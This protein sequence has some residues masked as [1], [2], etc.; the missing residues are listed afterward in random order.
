MNTEEQAKQKVKGMINNAENLICMFSSEKE[1]GGLVFGERMDVYALYAMLT[2]HLLNETPDDK[3]RLQRAY[4][5]GVH[6]HE[7]KMKNNEEDK[8]TDEILKL[9]DDLMIK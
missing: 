4:E 3:D 8:K 7:E 6:K 5:L 9:F 1:I 2:E